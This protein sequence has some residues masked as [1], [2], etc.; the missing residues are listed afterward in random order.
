[1]QNNHPPDCPHMMHINY[2]VGIELFKNNLH[3]IS[4]GYNGWQTLKPLDMWDTPV[5]ESYVISTVIALIFNQL[6]S[7]ENCTKLG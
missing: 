1:L 7:Y 3:M 2:G 6:H 4:Q 5:V